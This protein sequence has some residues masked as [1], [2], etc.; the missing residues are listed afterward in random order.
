MGIP[1]LAKPSDNIFEHLVHLVHLFEGLHLSPHP[2][3]PTM[4][5]TMASATHSE[6][7]ADPTLSPE[8][9][10][11]AVALD[12]SKHNNAAPDSL[13]TPSQLSTTQSD[14]T[15]TTPT[16]TAAP[17]MPA[18]GNGN[19]GDMSKSNADSDTVFTPNKLTWYVFTTVFYEAYCHQEVS[20]CQF[21]TSV[22]EALAATDVPSE[23]FLTHL[24]EQLSPKGSTT[25]SP[26]SAAHLATALGP[27]ATTVI[28]P[29]SISV[30]HA[31]LGGR[32]GTRGPGA[33]GCREGSHLTTTHE[34]NQQDLDAGGYE[35]NDT[36][37]SLKIVNGSSDGEEWME[38]KF[39]RSLKEILLRHGE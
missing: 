1:P 19:E 33:D 10:A 12:P 22:H 15:N 18:D 39:I 38:A 11:A 9:A 6:V 26:V 3:G 21:L 24:S 5:S 37:P 4:S 7:D 30:E 2:T 13:K 20:L 36:M 8:T 25:S 28:A 16:P 27:A 34:D 32:A 17:V 14:P 29:S 35:S 31:G 23:S